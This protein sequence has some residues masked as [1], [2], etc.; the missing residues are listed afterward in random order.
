MFEGVGLWKALLK[1]RHGHPAANGAG[2]VQVAGDV[3][4]YLKDKADTNLATAEEA[5]R[6]LTWASTWDSTL[7]SK[8]V[9]RVESSIG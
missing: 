2:G 9:G 4:K 7:W 8:R 1:V 6:S 3:G 5:S